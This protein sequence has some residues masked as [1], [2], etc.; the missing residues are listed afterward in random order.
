[1]LETVVYTPPCSRIHSLLFLH[2][3]LRVPLDSFQEF[4]L[5][6]DDVRCFLRDSMM[7]AR[8]SLV[9]P[10]GL[11]DGV[12]GLQTDTTF[13]HADSLAYDSMLSDT[14]SSA[15]LGARSTSLFE[16]PLQLATYLHFSL[17]LH[18]HYY[19]FSFLDSANAQPSV[20]RPT[21]IPDPGNFFSNSSTVREP[22]WTTRV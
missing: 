7:P 8:S 19:D 17:V 4:R 2:L 14:S 5:D 15:L 10:Q 12:D 9:H 13:T 3:L 22:A 18:G 6:L 1:M 16:Q 11:F 21:V 20:P